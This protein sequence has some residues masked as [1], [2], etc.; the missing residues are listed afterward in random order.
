QQR[1][2]ER[3]PLLEQSFFSCNNEFVEWASQSCFW[4][5][6]FIC[7]LLLIQKKPPILSRSCLVLSQLKATVGIRPCSR[8]FCPDPGGSVRMLSRFLRRCDRI[9]RINCDVRPNDGYNILALLPSA[10][11]NSVLCWRLQDT[12]IPRYKPSSRYSLVASD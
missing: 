1:T 7:G 5:F 10:S 8:N 11:R 3:H 12:G 9:D 6:A 2:S 4:T